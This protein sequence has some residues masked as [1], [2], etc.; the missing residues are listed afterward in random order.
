MKM[1]ARMVHVVSFECLVRQ[2]TQV[3]RGG[4][5]AGAATAASQ[6]ALEGELKDYVVLVLVLVLQLQPCIATGCHPAAGQHA[7]TAC[8]A[9]SISGS[10]L[11]PSE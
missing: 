11:Q 7:F 1:A 4:A 6:R 5:A 8:A 3:S 2:I 9:P 10:S